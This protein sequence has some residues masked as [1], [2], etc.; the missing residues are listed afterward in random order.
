MRSLLMALNSRR[1]LFL[2]TICLFGSHSL[3]YDPKKCLIRITGMFAEMPL[4]DADA[5]SLTP[6]AKMRNPRFHA[7]T[8]SNAAKDIRWMSAN[9]END[10]KV[11]SANALMTSVAKTQDREAFALLF[12]QFAPRLKS[13]MMKQG[14]EPDAAEEIAQET[15]ITVWHKA[16][17]FDAKKASASTWIFTIARNL[18]IDRLRKEKRPALDPDEPLLR[19]DN[20]PTPLQVVDR[21]EIVEQG[22]RSIEALPQDQQQVIRL[23]FVDGLTHQE[24]SAHLKLPLGTVKSRLRLSFEKLRV[25]L[26]DMR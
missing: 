17:Q 24:I 1:L 15:F 6:L 13:Y 7:L 8:T 9:I 14:A 20:Q 16:V 25:R 10:S 11:R 12:D 5:F 23:S 18:R 3:T 19:P 2:R 21:S 22:T 4:P 26:G